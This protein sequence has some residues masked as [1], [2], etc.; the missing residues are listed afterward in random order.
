M[1]LMEENYAFLRS[2]LLATAEIILTNLCDSLSD[3]PTNL[4]DERKKQLRDESRKG[5]KALR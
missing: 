5:N 1:S 4:E 3:A 2:F